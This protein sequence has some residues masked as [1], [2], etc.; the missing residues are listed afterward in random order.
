MRLARHL[1]RVPTPEE[2]LRLLHDHRLYSGS[3]DA[4][5]AR[6]KA[7]VRSILK[8]IAKSFD[9]SKCANGTVNVGKYDAWAWKHFPCGLRGRK[10]KIMTEDGQ[11]VEIDNGVHVGPEFIAV[12]LAVCEFALID[13]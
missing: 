6:R 11:V 2:A 4:N 13:G 1:K 9:A 8:F 3:W 7:R 5:L 12:V 10:R